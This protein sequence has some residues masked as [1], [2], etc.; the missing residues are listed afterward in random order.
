MLSQELR[1]NTWS[2]M[3]GQKENIKI[4]KAIVRDPIN[5]PKCLIFQG[6]FGSGKTTAARILARELNKIT[7]PKFDLLSSPFY[8]EFDSTVVGNVEEIRKLRDTF[9]INYGEYWRIIVFDEVH[10]VSTAAQTALLKILEEAEGR[11]IFVMCTTH[12]HKVLPTIRSRS[13]ELKFECVPE[14]EII[15]NLERV[16]QERGFTLSDEIKLLIADRSGGHMRNAHMLLDKYNLLGEQDFKDSIKSSITL[17]CDFLIA[18]HQNKGPEILKNLNSLLD[19]PKDDLQADFNTV[20]T[21]SMRGFCGFEVRHPD[22]QRMIDEW[23]TDFRLVVSCYM[24]SWIKNMFIDMPYF[25]ATMLNMFWVLRQA[26]LKLQAAQNP[27]P[28][29]QKVDMYSKYR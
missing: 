21:E 13:L 19:I 5:S 3:A 2:E 28:Q 15:E 4:L 25:Q 18:I 6:A 12:I 8:Y 23:K 16:S 7:D 10:A 14:D 24:E 9:T 29:Q 20:L 22:I 27:Q 17:Y 11:N 26:L 1:P